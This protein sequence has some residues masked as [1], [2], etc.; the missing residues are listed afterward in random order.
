MTDRSKYQDKVIRNYYQNREE[1]AIQRLQEL[2]TELYL[3]EGAKKR[4][5]LWKN[6]VTHL[7]ALKVSQ[8]QIDHLLKSD[9]A[10]LLATYVKTLLKK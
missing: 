9:K 2:A 6:A 10:E 5:Q 8:K 1:I 7:E 4:T 3:A